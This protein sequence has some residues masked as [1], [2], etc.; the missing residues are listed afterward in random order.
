MRREKVWNIRLG[1]AH[2]LA[3]TYPRASDQEFRLL[4]S[5]SRGQQ[6]GALAVTPQG[7]Y[8]QVNGDYLTPLSAGQVRRALLAVQSSQAWR[9][10]QTRAAAAAANVVVHVKRR[11]KVAVAQGD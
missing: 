11:R 1:D 2:W 3:H 4:G 6:V 7:Q 8:L 9:T 10:P 5:V